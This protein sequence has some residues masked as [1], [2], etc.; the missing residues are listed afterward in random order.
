MNP[1]AP[2]P[3]QPFQSPAEMPEAVRLLAEVCKLA[4]RQG[5]SDI[6][7]KIGMAPMLRLRGEIMPIPNAPR[8]TPETLGAMA[9]N[10]MSPTQRERF[11]NTHDLDMAWQVPGVGRFRVNVF[12][13]RQAI[14]MVLRAIPNQVKT[15]DELSLP[16]VL[17]KIAANPRGLVLV[18][19]TTGSG[20]STTLAALI[21]EINRTEPHH[22][23]TIEDPIEFGFQDRKAVI[24][25]REVGVDTLSFSTA[26][27]SAMRQDPDVMLV[28]ELRDLETVEIALAA[29]ETGHLVMSTLHTLDAP[30][31]INRLLGFF[32]PHHQQQIRMQIGSVL[33]AIISQRLM[34]AKMG[35][36]VPALEI[37]INTGTIYEC[38]IDPTR[39][40]EIPDHMARGASQYGTQTYDQSIF[41]AIHAGLIDVDT[42]LRYANNPDELQLRLSGIGG[43][44][45]A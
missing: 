4:V 9:W 12:R 28:G 17:K 14:G 35:G 32:E 36:R 37:M 34:P 20:K 10:I 42:G 6:H 7:L 44:D 29:A 5:A 15:I 1:S 18:T 11:K 40:K 21:E 45:W 2:P 27:R 16:P 19:G 26:L 23:V 8:M 30:E 41:R 38:I 25:Q 33:R 43:E 24:N 39:T 3:A 22:I 13:Q 31:S